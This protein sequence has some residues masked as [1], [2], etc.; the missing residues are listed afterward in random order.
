[1]WENSQ[2]GSGEETW[3][4]RE[5]KGG[6][7]TA[8]ETWVFDGQEYKA[9]FK[10]ERLGHDAL[11][12][13]GRSQGRQ[14]RFIGRFEGDELVIHFTAHEL[15]AGTRYYGLTRLRHQGR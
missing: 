2:G 4:I 10:G 5:E 11:W 15:D 3:E 1:M 12:L 6:R 9:E 14:Y 8:V 7:L 13:E